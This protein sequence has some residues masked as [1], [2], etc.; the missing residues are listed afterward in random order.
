[1][2][3]KQYIPETFVYARRQQSTARVPSVARETI[4]NGTLSE[5]KYSKYGLIEKLNFL[6]NKSI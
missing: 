5:L 3:Y 2:R 4:F 1:V 6:F